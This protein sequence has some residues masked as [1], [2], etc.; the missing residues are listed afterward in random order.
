MGLHKWSKN[1]GGLMPLYPVLG[2]IECSF[3]RSI[4]PGQKYHI[5]TRILGW[6]EKWI[7]VVSHF[8]EE[9]CFQPG[10]FSD[11]GGIFGKRIKKMDVEGEKKAGVDAERDLEKGNCDESGGNGRDPVFAVA[12]AK[13]VFK[14][15]RKTISPMQTFSDCELVPAVEENG[16]PGS[17]TVVKPA[18]ND[19]DARDDGPRVNAIDQQMVIAKVIEEKRLR[20]LEIAQSINSSEQGIPFDIHEDVA[21]SKF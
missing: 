4:K 12:M 21:F 19:D 14:N 13:M 7:F 15:G 16:P 17:V 10:V 8:V 2:G 9:G 1:P 3:R 11:G 5:V 18:E 20:G 6:N